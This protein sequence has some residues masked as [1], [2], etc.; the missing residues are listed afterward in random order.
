MKEIDYNSVVDRIRSGTATKEEYN[1]VHTIPHTRFIAAQIGKADADWLAAACLSDDA[2]RRM[3]AWRLTRKI[4]HLPQIREA[5]RKCWNQN[6]D[7]M[8]R[9]VILWR[10]L[11]DPELPDDFHRAI[12]DWT[13]EH[14]NSFVDWL[15]E[16]MKPRTEEGFFLMDDMEES[17]DKPENPR[18]KHWIYVTSSCLYARANPAETAYLKKASAFLELSRKQLK[19]TFLDSISDR[20]AEILKETDP[21]S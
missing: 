14:P 16:Y 5:V 2:V 11:D 6:L 21:V 19:G 20:L 18:S 9:N 12:W 7:E 3:A 13:E 4:P 10:L 15:V 17:L 1:M 8:E